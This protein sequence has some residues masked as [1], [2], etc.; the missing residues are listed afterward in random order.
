[1]NILTALKLLALLFS[2]GTIVAAIYTVVTRGNSGVSVILMVWAIIFIT[3]Y[4]NKKAINT[5]DCP[6]H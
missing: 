6:R 2:V 5:L 4:R 3:A 1:M